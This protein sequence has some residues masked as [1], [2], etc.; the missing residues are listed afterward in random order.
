VVVTKRSFKRFRRLM[1]F[2]VIERSVTNM[3]NLE[4]KQSLKEVEVVAA[5]LLLISCSLDKE[6]SSSNADLKRAS[7]FS[8][9]LK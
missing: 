7:P 4:K 1:K 2:L 3:I 8:I 5:P 9:L 6:G